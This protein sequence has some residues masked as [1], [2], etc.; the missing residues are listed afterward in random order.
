[1]ASVL[2]RAQHGMEAPLVRVE[3]DVAGGLPAFAIVGLPEAVVKESKD[4]V[5][6]AIS[7]SNFEVPSGRITVNL[8]PADLPKE[9]G[10]FDLPIAIGILL[11]SEQLPA[12][13]GDCEL[14]GELSL[15]GEVRS[16]RG[17]LLAAVAAARTGNTI[18][19]PPMNAAEARLV[20][21]C[22]VAVAAHLL[23]VAAHITGAKPLAFMH[24]TRPIAVPASHPDLSEVRGQSH[25]KRAL[26][27]AAA[28]QHSLLFIGA[29]GTGK[30]MLAQRLT[31]L[32]PRM[33]ETE[34]LESAAIRSIAGLKLDLSQWTARPFRSPHHTAS[35]IALVGGGSVPRP[36]EIS[37]AHNG[38][39]F[40]D[41]LPEFDRRVLE[42]LREPLETGTITISRAARQAEYPAVFQFIAAMNPCPCGYLGDAVGKCR[43]TEE[44]VQRYR[45]R[46]SGPLLDRLDMHVEM[47]R[48]PMD[49]MRM[50]SQTIEPT[51]VVAARVFQAR[52]IQVERQGCANARLTNREIERYCKPSQ[53]ATA[54][55]ERAVALLG[56]SARAH[57][58]VLKLARTIADLGGKTAIDSDHVSEAMA[59]RKLDRAK[60]PNQMSC[61]PDE[62]RDL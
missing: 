12:K 20:A 44:R 61:H 25:A 15:S 42:V 62:S 27:I 57:H 38:V 55:L 2:S 52:Q 46:I 50:S 14:Y 31:G 33:T 8:S 30:S 58:R 10:R 13:L 29:P 37:L 19:V 40:L 32:L 3:V 11:A 9:G 48:V 22:R 18:V 1:M 56:L 26:E 5:R 47:P 7:N 17:S 45:S 16:V 4:R 51:A 24:G 41:E 6:A 59:M 60:V 53:R 28:A 36:G 35:A 39:L 43:C 21:D 54:L 49:A 23:D 34:A